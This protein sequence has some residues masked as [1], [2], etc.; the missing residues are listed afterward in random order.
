MGY[1]NGWG[2]IYSDAS[3]SV[4]KEPGVVKIRKLVAS[5][6]DESR[7]TGK[8]VV[9]RY[10]G[11]VLTL[12]KGQIK[13]LKAKNIVVLFQDQFGWFYWDLTAANHL[14]RVS[15]KNLGVKIGE[16]EGNKVQ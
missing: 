16:K 9:R 7:R 11:P 15:E 5:V 6:L 2:G 14:M 10:D 13:I 4:A 1:H 8:P 3:L 12:S